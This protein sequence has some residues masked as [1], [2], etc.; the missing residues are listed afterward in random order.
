MRECGEKFDDVTAMYCRRE[1]EHDGD[2]QG[3]LVIT[4]PRA[5]A[6]RDSAGEAT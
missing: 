1:A 2:H 6:A 3:Y 5:A 4:W